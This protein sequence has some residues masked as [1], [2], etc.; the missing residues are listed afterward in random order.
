[1]S[2]RPHSRSRFSSNTRMSM[3]VWSTSTSSS[4]TSGRLRSQYADHLRLALRLPNLTESKAKRFISAIRR[5]KV[6]TDGSFVDKSSRLW[7]FK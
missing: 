1:M 6:R 4:G 3:V 2:G 5:W 7:A